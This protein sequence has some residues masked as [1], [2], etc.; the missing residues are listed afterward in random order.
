MRRID[1]EYA[2]R[3]PPAGR[4]LLAAGIVAAMATAG[5]YIYMARAA[6]QQKAQSVPRL[7]AD[8]DAGRT[9]QEIEQ[10]NDVARRLALPW[11]QL[12][13]AMENS[14]TDQVALLKVQPDPQQQRVNLGGEAR[15]YDDV[16]AYMLRLDASGT[17][18]KAELLSHQ[19]KND[20]PQHPVAFT[21]V[22][23]WR[24]PP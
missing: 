1:L 3:H 16:L 9:R 4:M 14:A 13:R 22:A 2:T 5:S 20:D 19:V 7:L 18:G 24:V 8:G 21:L 11:G 10:A 15:G 17:L 6:A 23:D 12:F